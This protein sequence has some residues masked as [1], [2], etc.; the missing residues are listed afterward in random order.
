MQDARPLF[1]PLAANLAFA[2]LLVRAIY[3][4]AH[5]SKTH[6]NRVNV[7]TCLLFNV[8]TFSVCLFL[9]PVP[10]ELGFAMG[11]C[12]V[13]GVLRYRTET[14]RTS[15]LSYLFVGIALGIVNAVAAGHVPW[16]EVLSVNTLIVG[17]TAAVQ[18]AASTERERSVPVLFDE[19]E[20]LAPE[21]QAALLENLTRRCNLQVVRA[22]VE[23]VDLLRDAAELTVFYTCPEGPAS[24]SARAARKR[25]QQLPGAQAA[26]GSLSPATGRSQHA[27]IAK[28][29]PATA[30]SP[31]SPGERVVGL[32]SA[33]APRMQ[34]TS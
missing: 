9:R 2:L 28:P 13:F 19:L 17:L 29:E 32:T 25:L 31:R 8:V 18:R 6:G 21:Q 34:S 11:L 4:K 33:A 10:I 14:V 7:L 15:D 30:P 24:S 16:L 22:K 26:N 5:G 20:L 12:A 23:R 27:L 1:L 3:W